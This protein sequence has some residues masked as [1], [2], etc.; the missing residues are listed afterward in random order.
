MAGLGCGAAGWLAGCPVPAGA[1]ARRRGR[2]AA[3]RPAQ[4]DAACL[5]PWVRQPGRALAGLAAAG[6]AGPVQSRPLAG[7]DGRGDRH[8]CQRRRQCD[9]GGPG[10]ALAGRFPGRPGPAVAAFRFRRHAF[11][12][13]RAGPRIGACL[14]GPGCLADGARPGAGALPHPANLHRAAG[15]PGPAGD[16]RLVAARALHRAGRP[17]ACSRPVAATWPRCRWRRWSS[18]AS[19]ACWRNTPG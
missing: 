8:R 14:R 13:G 2:A 5:G 15:R 12:S 10:G 19:P 11:G 17:C 18:S 3:R 9:C 1:A 7:G 16:D 6:R 4:L